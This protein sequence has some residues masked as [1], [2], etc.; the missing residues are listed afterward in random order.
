[1]NGLADRYE[2]LFRMLLDSRKEGKANVTGVTFW[3]LHDGITWLTF[4]RR[5]RS[6][7]LLFDEN[8]QP[9][10]AYE[11]VLSASI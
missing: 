7:P 3:G 4:F 6:Y 1:M 11:A 10:K 2:K 9:K 8:L 5:E